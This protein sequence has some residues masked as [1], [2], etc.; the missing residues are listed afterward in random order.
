MTVGE[1]IDR[2]ATINPDR[3]VVMSKDG[4]GNSK[5]PLDDMEECTYVAETTWCGETSP[6]ELT[7]ALE[8]QGFSEDDILKG[9]EPAL[10]LWPTN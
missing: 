4:E 1:L 10:C 3:I 9:G 2:L 6:E 7:P 8:G 5:S